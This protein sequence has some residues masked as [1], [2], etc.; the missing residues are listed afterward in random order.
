MCIGTRYY[1]AV[2]TSLLVVLPWVETALCARDEMMAAAALMFMSAAKTNLPIGAENKDGN[3]APVKDKL[4]EAM[5][6]AGSLTGTGVSSTGHSRAPQANPTNL[7]EAAAAGSNLVTA[8]NSAASGLVNNGLSIAGSNVPSV[9]VA[10]ATVAADTNAELSTPHV[11][12]AKEYNKLDKRLEGLI[13]QPDKK[14]SSVESAT[15]PPLYIQ[16]KL[17]ELEKK[18][19][20]YNALKSE[21]GNKDARI[22]ALISGLKDAQSFL[23]KQQVEIE[24][25]AENL[26]SLSVEIVQLKNEKEN[27]KESL[28]I[29]QIGKCEYYEIKEGDTCESIA[30]DPAVYGDET[31]ANLIRQA[32]YDNIKDFDN[33]TPGQI[34]VIPYFQ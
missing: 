15:S 24:R 6:A 23:N 10:N 8:G 21:I 11:A 29:L 5:K 2:F 28:R 4:A 34:L 16:G 7:P 17:Q 32:N 18:A 26:N 3:A 14:S 20:E 22:S 30:S 9:P 27:F 25:L 31:K 13:Q 12:L 33:L 19:F 1:K